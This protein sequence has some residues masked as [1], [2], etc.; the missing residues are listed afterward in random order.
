MY[1]NIR[2]FHA[3]NGMFNKDTDLTQG[4][5]GSLLIIAQ[6]RVGVLSTLA[7]LLRWDVNAVTT[8]V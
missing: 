3:A 2:T 1:Q 8:V 5:I 7:R 4:C 6:L